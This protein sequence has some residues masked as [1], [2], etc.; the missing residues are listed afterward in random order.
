MERQR[1]IFTVSIWSVVLSIVFLTL[2][3]LLLQWSFA[4]TIFSALNELNPMTHLGLNK[5]IGIFFAAYF[6]AIFLNLLLPYSHV[7]NAVVH[8]WADQY[9]TLF[10]HSVLERDYR[11]RLLLVTTTTNKVY[12]GYVR[13]IGDPIGDPFVSLV[14]NL[15]GYRDP[16]THELTITTD[17]IRVLTSFLQNDNF[18]EIEE[19][20]GV[21]ILKSNILMVSKFNRTL[22]NSFENK[23]QLETEPFLDPV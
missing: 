4:H 9:D 7:L 1:M 21:T 2:Y 19:S 3:Y 12:V 8:R 11:K 23:L 6:L 13:S 17:Y 22:F 14:P 5:S 10:W 20:L 18:T 16:K 15:S